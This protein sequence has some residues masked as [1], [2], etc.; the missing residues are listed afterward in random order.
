VG[1]KGDISGSQIPGYGGGMPV[2][3][4]KDKG[5]HKVA[6]GANVSV[7]GGRLGGGG[8]KTKE[9]STGQDRPTRPD[10]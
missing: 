9:T 4:K 10:F 5:T 7:R 1:G 2:N 8:K 6:E 3:K